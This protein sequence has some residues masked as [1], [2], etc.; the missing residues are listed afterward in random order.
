MLILQP[1]FRR[2]KTVK[3]YIE[4]QN[5]MESKITKLD[6]PK[7]NLYP[8]YTVDFDGESYPT[9]WME[10]TPQKWF[11]AVVKG[12]HIDAGYWNKG[13]GENCELVEIFDNEVEALELL[14]TLNSG[15]FLSVGWIT[16]ITEDDN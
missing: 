11:F 5:K 8:L 16:N 7:E 13:I 12:R 10:T 1:K 4:N 15:Y 9:T 14:K 2:R 6:V 3:Q